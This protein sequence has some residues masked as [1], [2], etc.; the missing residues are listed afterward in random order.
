MSEE[1]QPTYYILEEPSKSRR[2]PNCILVLIGTSSLLFGI[3]ILLYLT[4]FR[5]ID[6]NRCMPAVAPRI[7]V[8]EYSSAEYVLS[9]TYTFISN[10]LFVGMTRPEVLETLSQV[11][12]VR[13]E[14][15]Q[16]VP[17][18]Y[19]REFVRVSI[20]RHTLNNPQLIVD[21]SPE[22]ILKSFMVKID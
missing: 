19:E 8:E 22:G 14:N 21:Y 5:N 16:I 7:G 17:G 12:P 2:I 18:K 15:Q 10:S 9:E 4:L 1:K 13:V 11:G 3:L 20:C 6:L